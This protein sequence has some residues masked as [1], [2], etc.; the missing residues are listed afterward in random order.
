[1]QEISRILIEEYCMTHRKT[2]KSE[3]LWGLLELSYTME[4]VPEDWESIKLEKYISQ[5]KNPELKEFLP[6]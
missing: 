6:N 3:F 4:Y 1:M 2:K 5:E